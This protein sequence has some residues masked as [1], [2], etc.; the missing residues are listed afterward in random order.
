MG[1]H[2]HRDNKNDTCYVGLH[3][4][5]DY[6][7]G[8][9]ASDAPLFFGARPQ[10]PQTKQPLLPARSGKKKSPSKTKAAKEATAALES[11]HLGYTMQE[12]TYMFCLC[13]SS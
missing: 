11:L 10:H 5:C 8:T 7:Y 9:I 12:V 6:L 13:H 3:R 4:Y 1:T 2:M